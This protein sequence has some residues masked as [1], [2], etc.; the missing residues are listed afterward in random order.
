MNAF[1]CCKQIGNKLSH[2]ILSLSQFEVESSPF[3]HKNI[4]P[5]HSVVYPD[6]FMHQPLT[7]NVRL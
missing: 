7:Y 2:R 1:I 6:Q 3:D 5:M 4:E